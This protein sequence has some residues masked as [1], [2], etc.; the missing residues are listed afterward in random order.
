M[1][2]TKPVPVPVPWIVEI[3]SAVSLDQRAVVFTRKGRRALV[4]VVVVVVGDVMGLVLRRTLVPGS[5]GGKLVE[6]L[7][8]HEALLVVFL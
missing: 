4:V 8:Y 5:R 6:V 7:L 1:L 2:V 3:V